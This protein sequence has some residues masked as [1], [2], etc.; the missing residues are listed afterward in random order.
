MP[1]IGHGS[2]GD[3]HKYIDVY[4]PASPRPW[5]AD[6]RCSVQFLVHVRNA[7]RLQRGVC[8]YQ[9]VP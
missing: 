1:M 2:D 3:A 8:Q 7:P 9:S 6:P 4:S 5:L